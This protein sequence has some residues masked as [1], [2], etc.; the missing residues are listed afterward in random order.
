MGRVISRADRAR[1]FGQVAEEYDRL[2]PSPPAAAVDWLLPDR[3]ALVVDLAAGTG[4]LSRA[5]AARG[6]RV[7]AV[8]PDGRM[9]A[10]LRARSPG[11]GVVRAVGERIPLAPASA[12]GVFIQSAWHWLDPD[13]AI[14]EIAR[15]LRPGGCFGVL[16]PSRDGGRDWMAG[17]QRAWRGPRPAEPDLAARAG[18]ER[19]RHDAV[20]LPADGLFDAPDV[21]SFRYTRTMTVD[22][23]IG[24]FGT[25]SRVITADPAD[26]AA[27]RARAR[28]YLADR[29]PG[30]NQLEVPLLAQAWRA[31]RTDRPAPA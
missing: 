29:F 8:E 9:A 18:R 6:P 3:A 4:L 23:F 10:V 17:V 15:V 12:D 11:I 13:R 31:R 24:L 19:A 7:V 21:S 26:Q 16:W 30:A 14:P 25:Y 5:L 1:S 22:D 28:A 27:G 2:R 20:P